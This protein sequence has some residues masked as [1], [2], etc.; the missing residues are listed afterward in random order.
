MP[1]TQSELIR[2]RD[3]LP[4]FVTMFLGA[5][6]DILYRSAMVIYI[7]YRLADSLPFDPRVLITAVGG[8]LIMPFFIF[9]ALAGQAADKYER[10]KLIRI[11]KAA[12]TAIMLCGALSFQIGSIPLL[13]VVLFLMGTQSAFFG[14]LKYG[15]IPSLVSDDELVAA[16][17]LIEM[18]TFMAILLGTVCGGA[19]VMLPGGETIAGCAVVAAAAGGWAASLFIPRV[20]AVDPSLRFKFDLPAETV[21]LIRTMMP[22]R[23]VWRAILGASWFYLVGSVFIAQFPI[24]ARMN[25]GADSSVATLFMAI[26]SVGIGAGSLVCGDMGRVERA[27]RVVPVA[28]VLIALFGLCLYLV[29]PT[30]PQGADMIGIFGFITSPRCLAAAACMFA[31]SF[32]GG[33]FIVPLYATVQSGTGPKLAARA[34]ACMNVVDSLFMT[35]ASLVVSALLW[36]GAEVPEIFLAITTLTA[37]AGMMLRRSLGDGR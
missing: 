9:S 31:L 25:F 28:S 5:F 29:A 8:V 24:Y 22:M 18:G 13:T 33:L 15:V 32:S 20:P 17:A 37:A 11:T 16:N 10:T 19:L 36:L 12:E 21:R 7:T 35:A 34:G 14:P 6:N 1:R 27:A 4:H 23:R 2:S 26:F 30:Q 3:L